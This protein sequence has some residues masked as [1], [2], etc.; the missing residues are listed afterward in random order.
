MRTNNK[1]DIGQKELV[2]TA[3]TVENTTVAAVI[4]CSLRRRFQ[5]GQKELV[6]IPEAI[7][8]SIRIRVVSSLRAGIKKAP[9]RDAR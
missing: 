2:K 7:E 4:F 1:L 3:V 6:K 5:A 9:S 8:I